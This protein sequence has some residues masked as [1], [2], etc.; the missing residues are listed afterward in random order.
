MLW[1]GK[2]PDESWDSYSQVREHRRMQ[3]FIGLQSLVQPSYKGV[4]GQLTL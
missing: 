3:A 1:A 4:E 2:C